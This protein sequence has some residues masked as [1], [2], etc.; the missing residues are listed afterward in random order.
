MFLNAPTKQEKLRVWSKA[1]LKEKNKTQF[2]ETCM[3]R[4]HEIT[5]FY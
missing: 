3:H 5:G 4:K 1:C 2:K